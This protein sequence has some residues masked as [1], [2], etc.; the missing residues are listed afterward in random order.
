[1]MHGDIRDSRS[2]ISLSLTLNR[3][4]GSKVGRVP[5]SPPIKNRMELMS[6]EI[7]G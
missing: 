3:V 4:D 5:L 1:M 7:V 6:G 2:A